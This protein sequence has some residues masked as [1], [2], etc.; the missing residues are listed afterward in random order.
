MKNSTVD[1]RNIDGKINED[2]SLNKWIREKK[3]DKVVNSLF[4]GGKKM[5]HSLAHSKKQNKRQYK[6]KNIQE[7]RRKTHPDIKEFQDN[8]LPFH[9]IPC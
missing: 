4:L 9:P 7:E 5:N 2:E 3:N 6:Y 1:P 8:N